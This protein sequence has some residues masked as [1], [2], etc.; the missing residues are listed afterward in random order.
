MKFRPTFEYFPY[1]AEEAKSEYMFRV[2]MIFET[3]AI[4]ALAS[5]W[6]TLDDM[7]TVDTEDLAANLEAVAQAARSFGQKMDEA[8]RLIQFSGLEAPLPPEDIAR[9]ANA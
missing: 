4:L 2:G 8:G 7:G 3:G 1:N 5:V 6:E 9:A